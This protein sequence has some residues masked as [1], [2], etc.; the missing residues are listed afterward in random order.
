MHDTSVR[1]LKLGTLS[2]LLRTGKSEHLDVDGTDL[3]GGVE[4]WLRGRGDFVY[5]A[6]R[7]RVPVEV[8]LG[9]LAHADLERLAALGRLARRGSIR[10]TWGTGVARA[11]GELAR[12]ARTREE[13]R[14][15]QVGHLIPAELDVLS[16][17][18]R[19][20]DRGQ[21][22]LFVQRVIDAPDPGVEPTSKLTDSSRTP[23]GDLRR[24]P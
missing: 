18:R 7:R 13:L 8:Q 3:A 12:A 10:R 20:T 4:S 6:F 14:R 21:L 23:G 1:Y 11:A 19:L 16:G 9:V 15:I 17:K 5:A 2:A 22:I 24:A